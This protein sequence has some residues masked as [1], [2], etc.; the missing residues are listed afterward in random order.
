MAGIA[1]FIVLLKDFGVFEFYLPFVILFAIMYGLLLK[2]RLFGEGSKARSINVIISLAAAFYVMAYTPVGFTLTEYFANFFTQV[3]VVLVTLVAF[4]MIIG[5]LVPL[6]GKMKM[7]DAF[8]VAGKWIILFG[9]LIALGMFL[10]SGGQMIFP[11]FVEGF[12][13]GGLSISPEL[14]FIIVLIALTVLA[15]WYMSKGEKEDKEK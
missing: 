2:S 11:G 14:I 15:I 5:L 9:A 3:S 12:S 1:D 8:K 10:S 4:M 7:E 6:T 13:F